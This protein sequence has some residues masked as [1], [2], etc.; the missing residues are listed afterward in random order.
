MTDLK[1]KTNRSE[2]E[3]DELFAF[4]PDIDWECPKDVERALREYV[5]DELG[6]QGCYRI[7]RND[8]VEGTYLFSVDEND[9]ESRHGL[10]TW[11]CLTS[12][13]GG[14]AEFNSPFPEVF[15][16]YEQAEA[17]ALKDYKLWY[18]LAMKRWP[19]EKTVKA[20]CGMLSGDGRA[21]LCISGRS[22]RRKIRRWEIWS[23]PVYLGY[24][25]WK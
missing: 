4:A 24:G 10:Q 13:T 14:D 25:S 18:E 9:V 3:L 20:F 12:G 19:D 16:T 1:K 7:E 15:L 17:C 6:G 5:K 11:T 2:D 21:E 8:D 23:T 22:P